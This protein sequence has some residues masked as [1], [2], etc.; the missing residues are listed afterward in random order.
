MKISIPIEQM[1]GCLTN[2]PTTIKARYLIFMAGQ[3]KE[4]ISSACKSFGLLLK[5]TCPARVLTKPAKTNN[6][7]FSQEMLEIRFL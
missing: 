5:Y 6:I 1:L 4:L 3:E 2:K 7:G